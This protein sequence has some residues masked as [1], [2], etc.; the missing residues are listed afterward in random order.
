MEKLL[1]GVSSEI[2]P[3]QTVLVHSPGPEV[4]RMTPEHV[5]RALYSD[6]LSLS[7]AAEEHIV[8]KQL[9]A[10]SATVLEVKDLLTEV[11][12]LDKVKE[13]LVRRIAAKE[14]VNAEVDFLLQM[15]PVILATQL[16]EGVALK[17]DNLSRYLSDERY[18][19]RPL[20]NILFT[21]D[22]SMVLWDEVLIGRMAKSVRERESLLMEAIF[23]HHPALGINQIN[24]NSLTPDPSFVSRSTIEGG[25]VLVAREDVLVIGKGSRTSSEGI[26]FLIEILKAKKSGLKHL[27]VQE[28]PD[29]PESFIHLDMI[30]TFLSQE[31]CLIYEPLLLHNTKFQTIHI[32]IDN[33][34]VTG[35]HQR[36]NLLLALQQIGIDLKPLFC[37]GKIDPWVMERE[38]WHSGANCF[39]F[40]P[41]KVIG[42]ERNGYTLDEMDKNGFEIHKADDFLR[43][44]MNYSDFKKLTITMPGSELARGGG[45]ARCMTMPIGREKISW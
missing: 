43:N 45:G 22:P 16:I 29:S 26:D 14:K 12:K 39:A 42:Y 10:K 24:P 36:K 2:G 30:F 34:I 23:T 6:I 9:L 38:Q 18:S 28:L 20:H 13:D 15:S 27:I 33:G 3:L 8:L 19:V 32:S 25:D 37:G 17:R 1:V 40:E 41:G 7:S 5:E 11:L 4:E 21:R 31:F 35:I 44:G